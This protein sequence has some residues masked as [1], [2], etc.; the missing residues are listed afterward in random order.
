MSNE[1]DS[2]I[3]PEL[4]Q[5]ETSRDLRAIRSVSSVA[6]QRGKCQ[7]LSRPVHFAEARK[8][9]KMMELLCFSGFFSKL[10]LEV[11][12]LKELRRRV[13]VSMRSK[14]LIGAGSCKY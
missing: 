5:E 13:F 8:S 1:Q 10:N 11:F 2:T 4:R 14:G 9:I 12:I 6:N 3:V 7:F